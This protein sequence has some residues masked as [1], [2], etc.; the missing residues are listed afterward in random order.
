VE[1]RSTVGPSRA[2]TAPAPDKAASSAGDTP[3][4]GPTITRIRPEPGTG[5]RASGI[6]A[7]GSSRTASSAD[8]TCPSS[9]LVV[10]GP[11]TSGSQDRRACLAASRAAARQRPSARSPRSPCQRVT[12]RCADQGMMASTPASVISST[13]SWPRSPLGS[14]CATVTAGWGRGSVWRERTASATAPGRVA[15]TVH[16]ATS[17]APSVTSTRSPGRNRRTVAAW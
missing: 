12:Q 6:A 5:R 10:T 7:A 15:V 13:A 3:P 9:S 2:L 1:V 16:C 4:S 8:A 11:L 17:P 14:A